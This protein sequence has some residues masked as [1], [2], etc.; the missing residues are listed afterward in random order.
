[1]T[2]TI[3]ASTVLTVLI[4]THSYTYN[5]PVLYT[6]DYILT[7]CLALHWLLAASVSTLFGPLTLDLCLGFLPPT[8]A[9]CLDP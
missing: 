1:M 5:P 2:F 4:M 8:A 7:F 6:S 9:P 3:L